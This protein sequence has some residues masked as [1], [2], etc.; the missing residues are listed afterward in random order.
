MCFSFQDEQRGEAEVNW[1]GLC[2][3]QALLTALG[4]LDNPSVARVYICAA[5]L[6]RLS[7]PK[8]YG[9]LLSGHSG[10]GND[11]F[12]TPMKGLHV[13]PGE[14]TILLHVPIFQ[15]VLSQDIFLEYVPVKSS[16][17]HMG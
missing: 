6:P 10:G 1:E 5:A 8:A 12:V 11:H 17:I 16:N 4:L 3:K 14:T 13:T 15:E 9:A 2:H 7:L